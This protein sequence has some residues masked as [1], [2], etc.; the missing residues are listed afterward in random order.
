MTWK[1]LSNQFVSQFYSLYKGKT[2][3]FFLK[4]GC[5]EELMDEPCGTAALAVSGCSARRSF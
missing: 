2:M 1:K 5:W 3:A 4:Q